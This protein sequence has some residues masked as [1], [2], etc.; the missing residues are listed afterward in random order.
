MR[1]VLFNHYG[2]KTLTAIVL[3]FALFIFF[4]FW[5]SVYAPIIIIAPFHPTMM[6]IG[7]Y[8]LLTFH[9]NI[10]FYALHNIIS[11]VSLG[12]LIFFLLE[13]YASTSSTQRYT[14]D[15]CYPILYGCEGAKTIINSDYNLTAA[16]DFKPNTLYL[17][18]IVIWVYIFIAL[19]IFNWFFSIV[20]MCEISAFEQSMKNNTSSKE[21]ETD[22]KHKIK[23]CACYQSMA[24]KIVISCF[25]CVMFFT[26]LAQWILGLYVYT[27]SV[28]ILNPIYYNSTLQAVISLALIDLPKLKP[29]ERKITLYKPSKNVE[30][31]ETM[32]QNSNSKLYL[33][34]IK[35]KEMKKIET[36]YTLLALLLFSVFFSLWQISSQAVWLSNNNIV[37]FDQDT[38]EDALNGPLYFNFTAGMMS[39][40]YSPNT[41]VVSSLNY[42]AFSKFTEIFGAIDIIN[43]LISIAL[44][45]L[46]LF[47]IT[48]FNED[49]KQDYP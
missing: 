31:M 37:I 15:Y 19:S 20:E 47:Y 2:V 33:S 1:S 32:L 17:D 44:V 3:I 49:L 29:D 4:P 36:L 22:K 6:M 27:I 11:I 35:V 41:E 40:Q 34:D 18:M 42:N 38:Y 21:G 24:V 28:I 30:D 43:L 10:K 14:T 7:N 9:H 12:A 23:H 45:P 5:G 13:Y 48:K 8:A 25:A 46:L 16:N 39:I 26:C